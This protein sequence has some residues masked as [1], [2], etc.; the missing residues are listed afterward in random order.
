MAL[1]THLLI[2][3]SSNSVGFRFLGLLILFAVSFSLHSKHVLAAEPDA[4]NL[5][6]FA[7]YSSE[8]QDSL[9]DAKKRLAPL[10][11]KKFESSDGVQ[12][13]FNVGICTGVSDDKGV[14]IQQLKMD[15]D[16]KIVERHNLGSLK[17]SHILVGTDWIMLEYREGENYGNH[18]T[19]EKKRSVV[20]ITCD[21]N[22]DDNQAQ[23][24]FMKEENTKTEQCY[25]LF[26]MK[27]QAACPT[28]SGSGSLSVGTILVIVFFSVLGVYLLIGFLYARF[29]LRAKGI[30]QIPNYEF[31]KDFGNLQADGCDFICRTKERRRMDHFGGIGDDQLESAEEIRDDN[32]LPM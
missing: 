23:M 13:K 19:G 25:Y 20:M 3:N 18:C 32:L 12:W 21:P 24:V 26:E 14:A 28:V 31:W 29:V 17:D 16:N 30:E 1:V 5:C 8:S 4:A 9:A 6:E 15:S 27:H 22:I 10:V 2:V 11:G 7:K